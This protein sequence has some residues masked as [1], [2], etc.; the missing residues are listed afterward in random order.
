MKNFTFL[1]LLL[2][3]TFGYAQVNLPIDFEA[4]PVTADFVDFDGGTATV[5]ANPQ[6]S[7]INTSATVAQIIRD[8]GQPWAGSKLILSSTLDFTTNN[9]FTMKVF[10]P[11][12]G[13]PV[14]FKL[15][16]PGAATPDNVV[17]TTVANEWETLTWNF[18]GAPSNTYNEVVF[19]FDFGTV[20]DGTANSTFLFDDVEF[21]DISGGLAQIDLPITFEETATVYYDLIDFEGGGPSSIVVDPTDPTN[22]VAQVIKGSAA[23]TSAGT[24][25]GGSGIATAIPF[26]ADDT[27]MNV[28]VWSPDAGIQVRLKV[29]KTGDPTISVET[30]TVSTM[31]G[32]WETL[33]FDFSNEA[34]G[35]A[36]LN[37]ANTYDK[38]SIF[39][40]FG[41]DGAA[42]GEKTYYWDDVKFGAG[43]GG[44]QLAQVDLPITFENPLTIDYALADFGG[45]A[46]EVVVDPTNM[47]NLVG[48]AVKTDVAETWA[49]T[50]NGGNGLATALPFTAD[51]TK[52]S[53]RV[54]S[55]DAGTPV[56]L[57][58]EDASDGNIS[59]ETIATT[60]AAQAWE[61][62]EFDFSN[63][64]AGTAALNIANTYDKISIFFNFGT[65]GATAGE[66][67]YFWDDVMFIGGGGGPT[68][69]QVD[70]PVTF[71]DVLTIDYALGDFGGNESEIV[72]DPTDP[73]NKVV[74]ATKTV[75][76]ETWAGTTAGANGL[77]TAI[78]LTATDTKM[79]VRVWS[80]DAGTPVLLKV[81][82]TVDGAISVE[83]IATTTAAAAW[84]TLEFDFT[85]EAAGTPALD[86]T[87]TYDKVS[88]FFNFGTNGATAGEKTYYFDDVIFSG[89]TGIEILNATDAGI[90]ISPN[91][92]TEF[93]NIEFKE[94]FN[95]SVNVLLFSAD[96]RM[97]KTIKTGDQITQLNVNDLN[98][99]FYVLRIDTAEK[100]YF[101]KVMI[102]K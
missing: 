7:G 98:T 59:V 41:V 36:T 66:K 5:I 48:K 27:K 61:T 74:Q 43:G 39:F 19:I 72:T 75:V 76:A 11:A 32:A 17:N 3:S 45:N 14:L 91:P 1:M 35:T 93:L 63:E 100:S 38:V 73:N 26:T 86:L 54:W 2:V 50:T 53:V 28:R 49:G 13:I 4:T 95:E 71:E 88:I 6:S 20:G 57:K 42:A 16:G 81:E 34:V 85:N 101:Q 15:E 9:S 94:T 12:A 24:T 31:A 69:L 18:S 29:E 44:G 60:T 25:M 80:P 40:N 82:N 87:K 33:E 78:P 22:M 8:G 97:V 64:A 52:M 62:L 37:I 47:N 51:D 90:I 67:T 21:F 30:A 96:G 77:A 55:P 23:G 84:E 99:G 102:S 83:T 79:T 46:S 68:L 65:D 89:L 56:L 10:S 70:L 92:A 58:V